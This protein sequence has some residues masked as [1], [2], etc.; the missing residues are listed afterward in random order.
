MALPD[1]TGEKVNDTYQRLLQKSGSGQIVDGTGSAFIPS[2]TVIW[3]E[4]TQ[5]ANF[6][7]ESNKGYLI[8]SSGSAD[9]ITVTLPSSPSFA[10]QVA[11]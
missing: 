2:D 11:V 9:G 7:A 3:V 5:S 8:N 10:D 4:T 6:T 1:L